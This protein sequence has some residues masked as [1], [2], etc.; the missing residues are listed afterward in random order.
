MKRTFAFGILWLIWTA[1]AP[2]QTSQAPRFIRA[3]GEGVVSVRPDAG[4]V[5]FSVV[6]Q[7][8]TAR[9]AADQN[10]TRTTALIETLQQLIGSN[11]EI[12]TLYYSLSPNYNRDNPP[13]IIGYTAVN[14]IQATIYDLSLIGLLIDTGLQAGANRADGPRL[15][16]RND[17]EARAQAL[18]Q[19]GQKARRRAEAIAQG[20]SVRLGSVRSAEEG[21]SIRPIAV[22]RGAAPSAT[23][24]PIE[25]GA[26]EVR[27]TVTLEMDIAQ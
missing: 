6:T 3:F 8:A 23:T 1:A 18:R 14:T 21:V 24:T 13:A 22:E 7:A 11:G 20:V 19:A 27:A 16:L 12:K 5:S 15:T 2:A 17:E 9:E 10:A 26:L 4:A 25:T